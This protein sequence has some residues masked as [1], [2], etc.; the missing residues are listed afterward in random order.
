MENTKAK[1]NSF[2]PNKDSRVSS[3]FFDFIRKKPE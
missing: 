2:E 1:K 3:R